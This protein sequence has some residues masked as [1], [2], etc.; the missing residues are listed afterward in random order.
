MS[1]PYFKVEAKDLFQKK[2]ELKKAK[3]LWKDTI[4]PVADLA[5]GYAFDEIGFKQA[6]ISMLLTYA[7]LLTFS[8]FIVF[9]D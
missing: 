5:Y 6:T 3:E 9:M 1:Y 7:R 2:K 4:K 8:I